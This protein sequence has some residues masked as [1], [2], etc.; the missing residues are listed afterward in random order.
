MFYQF[1]KYFSSYIVFSKTRQKLLFIAFFGLF[2]S[3]FSLI[4]LQSTMG[5]LQ[6]KLVERSKD[7]GGE[8]V[9]KILQ[10]DKSLIVEIDKFLV[11]KEIRF[12]KE[13]ELELLVR[14]LNFMSPVVVHALV[15]S[16]VKPKFMDNAINQLVIPYGISIKLNLDQGDKAILISPSHVDSFLGDVPR[17]T[18]EYVE[19][20]VQTEVP[21][22]DEFHIWCPFSLIQNITRSE[23]INTFRL[24]GDIN[25]YKLKK[26]IDIKFK[27]KIKLVTWEDQNST[28]VWSLK[29][30]S[31]VMIFL[32]I[33][34]SLLVS[35]SITS[36]LFIFFNRIKNDLTSFWILGSSKKKLHKSFVFFIHFLSIISV[37]MGIFVGLF[38]LFLMDKY[39]PEILPDLFIDRKIPIHVTVSAL[40]ISFI[41]PYLISIVFSYFSLAQFK[42]EISYIH[43][44]R[45]SS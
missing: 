12:Y 2:I 17:F 29:L 31:T 8:A 25:W 40:G 26:I 37:I 3:A 24:W 18:S 9:I 35:L 34:M 16:N 4:V 36:G 21:E 20:I 10:Y 42:K 33:S 11:E 5:G 13:Y 44:I 19:D 6:Y 41:V 28:L 39:A 1:I 14:H 32:F 23:K 30:E 38:F 7:I 43:Q 22:I 15:P 45:S 27:N